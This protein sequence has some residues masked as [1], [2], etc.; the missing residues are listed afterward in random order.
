MACLR[1]PQLSC[2]LYLFFKYNNYMKKFITMLLFLTP[3]LALGTGFVPDAIWISD[4]SPQ[5]GDVVDI[6]VTIFNSEDINLQG[7]VNYYDDDLLLGEVPITVSSNSAKLVPLSWEATQGDRVIFAR[8]VKSNGAPEETK[9]L[10]F[11]VKKP[12][13]PSTQENNSNLEGGT[14][15]ENGFKDLA[16]EAGVIASDLAEDGFEIAEGGR[17]ASS[18]FLQDKKNQAEESK[19]VLLAGEGNNEDSEFSYNAKKIALVMLIWLLSALIF[20]TGSKIIFYV[21]ILLIITLI[22][23]QILIRRSYYD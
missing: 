5:H 19:A 14:T 21:S 16:G 11:K 10:R 8:F 13:I 1:L 18:D 17:E 12:V 3:S 7:T 9:K 6:F 2:F 20:I 4:E 22:I 23:R 15:G